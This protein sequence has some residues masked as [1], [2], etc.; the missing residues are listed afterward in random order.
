MAMP[1]NTNFLQA[2]EGLMSDILNRLQVSERH[3]IGELD[4]GKR[5]RKLA[6]MVISALQTALDGKNPGTSIPRPDY[7]AGPGSPSNPG[8]L[9]TELSLDPGSLS[10]ADRAANALAHRMGCYVPRERR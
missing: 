10:N 6:Q 5:R 7:E 3:R 9:G 8:N 1:D 2:C 4:P